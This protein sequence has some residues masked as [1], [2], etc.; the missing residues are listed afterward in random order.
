MYK[1]QAFGSRK[2]LQRIFS[3]KGGRYAC[4]CSYCQR[5]ACGRKGKNC[6]KAC[7][8]IGTGVL[9][10]CNF[11]NA[12]CCW[13]CFPVRGGVTCLPVGVRGRALQYSNC[14]CQQLRQL[15]QLFLVSEG[16]EFLKFFENQFRCVLL[17]LHSRARR[18]VCLQELSE[19]MC[20]SEW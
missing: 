7:R 12:L 11:C 17:S 3:L 1:Q 20:C 8:K 14:L 16:L 19:I 18:L 13:K 4:K 6:G 15:L 9:L 5:P 2:I 10:Y